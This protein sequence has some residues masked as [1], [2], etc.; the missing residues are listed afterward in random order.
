MVETFGRANDEEVL[1]ILDGLYLEPD[2][3]HLTEAKTASSFQLVIK[4][5]NCHPTTVQSPFDN[6]LHAH[7]A[8]NCEPL[9]GYTFGKK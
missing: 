9:K 1:I 6:H 7:S 4:K 3:F 5:L 8:F 2:S